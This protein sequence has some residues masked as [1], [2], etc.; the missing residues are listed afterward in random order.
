MKLW[1][2]RNSI[3]AGCAALAFGLLVLQVLN[4]FG[5]ERAIRQQ[6]SEQFAGRREQA[7]ASPAALAKVEYDEEQAYGVYNVEHTT[8]LYLALLCNALAVAAVVT[9]VGLDRRGA[10]PPPKVLLHY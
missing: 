2:W 9:R 4:G 7:A 1:P 3:V 5:M 10:K 6:I 8:W